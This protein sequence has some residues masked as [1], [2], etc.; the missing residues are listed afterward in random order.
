[1]E[2]KYRRMQQR[3]S[4]LRGRDWE[5]ARLLEDKKR[6]LGEVMEEVE[7]EAP[8]HPVYIHP[9]QEEVKEQEP[10]SRAGGLSISKVGEG[11]RNVP[12]PARQQDQAKVVFSLKD[13]I[14]RKKKAEEEEVEQ[15]E[16]DSDI[17]EVGEVKR[18]TPEEDGNSTDDDVSMDDDTDSD[19]E[20]I[21]S[22]KSGEDRKSK[23]HK[24]GSVSDIDDEIDKLNNISVKHEP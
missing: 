21:K 13:F 11:F 2:A 23:K 5:R 4:E 19:L 24:D 7:L 20:L 18:D 22:D 1:M 8:P 10:R 12:P 17:E 6:L 3:P 14:E 16:D 9:V 15:V